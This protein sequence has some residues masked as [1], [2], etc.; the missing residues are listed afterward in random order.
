MKKYILIAML[1]ILVPLNVTFASSEIGN[2]DGDRSEFIQENLLKIIEIIDFIPG[3]EL[4]DLG[5]S[6]PYVKTEPGISTDTIEE[7]K[8]INFNIDI[9]GIRGV[10]GK[11]VISYDADFKSNSSDFSFWKIRLRCEDGVSGYI[12]GNYEDMCGNSTLD[13]TISK[14]GG[15][16]TFVN[17]SNESARATVKFRAFDSSGSWAGS[18]SHNVRLQPSK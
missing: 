14:D 12:E 4:S 10:F 9:S 7:S 15:K 8:G 11:T 6:I 17:N 1:G 2:F 16:V 13:H 18:R 5:I 3:L